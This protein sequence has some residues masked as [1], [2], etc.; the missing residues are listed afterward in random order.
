MAQPGRLRRP[1]RGLKAEDKPIRANSP[2]R[3]TH[4]NPDNP[5]AGSTFGI[6]WI[7]LTARPPHR[8]IRAIDLK[9]FDAVV[10]QDLRQASSIG[11]RSLD[12]GTAD[13]PERTRPGKQPQVAS[14]SRFN[15]Q[16]RKKSASDVDHRTDMLVKMGVNPK[17]D[18]IMIHL[19]IPSQLKTA[20]PTSTAGQDT[21]GAEQR[22]Y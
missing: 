10:P 8:S 21:Q 11:G 13:I 20:S 16:R 2:N 18:F 1:G 5:R 15:G 22:S 3:L 14:G 19:N 17:N 12:S 6:S 9:D 7:C 4:R